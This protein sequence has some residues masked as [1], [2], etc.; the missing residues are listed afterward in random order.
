MVFIVK[1]IAKIINLRLLSDCL[2]TIDV[3]SDREIKLCPDN[4][5]R[6][7]R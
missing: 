2:S 1:C 5:Y 6:I 4:Q 3:K 7:K